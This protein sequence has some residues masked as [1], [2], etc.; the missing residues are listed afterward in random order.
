MYAI[1]GATGKVGRATVA[2][3]PQSRL[4]RESRGARRRQGR[5]PRAGRLR[6]QGGGAPRRTRARG[7]SRR[8]AGGAGDLPDEPACR[9]CPWRY[10]DHR[11]KHCHGARGSAP[12]SRGRYLGLRRRGGCG[13]R[14]HAALSR[15]RGAPARHRQRDDVSPLRGAD[16]ELDANP[17]VCGHER[18]A[19][20]HASSVDEGVSDGFGKRRRNRR[21]STSCS[22]MSSPGGSA[23]STSRVRGA[24]PPSTS[25]PRSARSSRKRSRPAS[26]HALSGCRSCSAPGSAR[27]TPGSWSSSTTHT[28][29]GA[30]RR[31]ARRA[32]SVSAGRSSARSSPRCSHRAALTS[33][34]SRTDWDTHKRPPSAILRPRQR[35]GR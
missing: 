16:A 31:S 32:K 20:E 7:G 2:R 25:R 12:A 22:T 3:A 17:Q 23:S 21:G 8:C 15:V 9:R 33:G 1:L 30:S 5:R 34:P 28:T 6:A 29:R 19:A 4:A 11:R 14:G 18:S 27:V 13:Q 35:S 10:A 24:I 26:S